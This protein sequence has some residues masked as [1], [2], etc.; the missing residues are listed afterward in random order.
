MPRLGR[1]VLDIA[2]GA[3]VFEGMGQM[4]SPLAIA[5]L[6]SGTRGGSTDL[7]RP[8]KHSAAFCW[9]RKQI[10]GGHAIKADC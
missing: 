5:S 2:S 9:F 7:L 1:A 8:A 10:S 4:R 3:G 6:I